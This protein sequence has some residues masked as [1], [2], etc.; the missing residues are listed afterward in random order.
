MPEPSPTFV[1]IST[2]DGS[3]LPM[4]DSY[5]ACS[6]P[7]GPPTGGLGLAAAGEVCAGCEFLLDGPVLVHEVSASAAANT[8]AGRAIKRWGRRSEVT[9]WLYPQSRAWNR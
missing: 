2:M 5:C 1:V 3:T 7:A 4:T 8:A 9:Q 6:E